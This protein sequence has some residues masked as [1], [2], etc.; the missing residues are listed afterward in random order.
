MG[1]HYFF[2]ENTAALSAVAL[3]FV[4]T[5]LFFLPIVVSPY[6]AF[7]GTFGDTPIAMRTPFLIRYNLEHGINST[8]SGLLN[9]PFGVDISQLNLFLPFTFLIFVPLC[10]ATSEVFAYNA[11]IFS[12]PFL[13][14]VAAFFLA[15]HFI[16]SR[17][18][19]FLS[20]LIYGFSPYVLVRSTMHPNLVQVAW[21]PLFVLALFRFEENRTYLNAIALAVS[22]ALTGFFSEYYLFFSALF[23]AI[24]YIY[25]LIKQRGE[26]PQKAK[27]GVANPILFV[28]EIRHYLVA[29]IVF[30][31]IFCIVMLPLITIMTST[32]DLRLF[33]SVLGG[34]TNLMNIVYLSAWP[35][36]FVTPPVYHPML[37]ETLPA[38]LRESLVGMNFTGATVFVGFTTLALSFYALIKQKQNRAVRFFLFAAVAVFILAIGPFVRYVQVFGLTLSVVPAL[39]AFYSSYCGCKKL[40]KAFALIF[41]LL[42]FFPLLYPLLPSVQGIAADLTGLQQLRTYSA[43]EVI[44]HLEK[45]DFLPIPMPSFFIFKLAPF[46][47]AYARLAV[48]LMLCLALLA[49]FGAEQLLKKIK[50]KKKKNLAAIA[51]GALILFEFINFPPYLATDASKTP[52]EYEWLAE[53]PGEFIVAEYPLQWD[54]FYMFYQLKHKK[55][56]LNGQYSYCYQQ[57]EKQLLDL[58]NEETAAIL[59]GLGVK[60]VITHDRSFFD[61]IQDANPDKQMIVNLMA[62]DKS[63]PFTEQ[64]DKNYGSEFKGLLLFKTFEHARVYKVTAEPRQVPCD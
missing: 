43:A 49:G 35:S 22:L 45:Y 51:L 29:S 27:A 5:V 18:A 28:K 12:G 20:G 23:L 9:A 47:R 30:L 13:A 19:C 3:Y 44:E 63:L 16:K 62:H 60:Y 17:P 7:M 34:R 42:L 15:R 24:F 14:A 52:L 2:R 25:K 53:Q 58:S 6:S 56:L 59:S 32:S 38:V 10:M 11:V 64:F 31:M 37:R 33:K 8:K 21:M 36:H 26:L 54:N 57:I 55:P 61:L 1:L 46:F 39:L 41:V 48:L 4:L 40:A 50:N